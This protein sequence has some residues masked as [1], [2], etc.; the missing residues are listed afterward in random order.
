M[1]LFVLGL[2]GAT[3]DCLNPL[4][5]EGI[6]PNI[7]ELCTHGA[8]GPLQTVF[9]PVTAPA[10]LA[11]ATGLNPGK[12]GVFDYINRKTAGGNEMVPVSSAYYQDKAV[13]DLLGRSNFKVGIFNYPTLS[14]PPKVNGFVVS[15]MGGYR[16]APLSFPEELEK[17]L[18]KLTGGYE[19][20]L[21]LRNNKYRKDVN[22]FFEDVNRV[23]TKQASALKYL[24]T[25]KEWDFFFAVFHFT[26]WMQHLLW[27]HIDD[28]HLLY[29][30]ILSPRI[31]ARFKNTWT[32]I[33]EIIGE[34]LGLIG[35]TSFMIVS[36]H[37]A[38]P[39]DSAF[40]PNTWLEQKGL[41][42]K[43]HLGW[44]GLLAE[45]L[46]PLSADIDNKYLSAGLHIL[47]TRI[48]KSRGTM[49][50][51]DL[52]NSLAYSPEHAGMFGCISLTQ[53]GKGI[54]GIKED[55][56]HELK[57]LPKNLD[58]IN[59][60]EIYLP[61]Q[62]YS[63]PYVNLAP[64]VLFVIN[65]YRSTVEIDFTKSS[66]VPSP[67]IEMRTGSH[68]PQGVFMAKG[69]NFKNVRLKNVSVLDI[70][71]TILALYD[72]EIPAQIDGK[73]I[74]ECIRPEVLK[75]MRIRRSQ[76]IFDDKRQIEENGDL[77]EMKRTLESMGYM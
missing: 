55:L 9:P 47:K 13:W 67:S 68:R 33:D 36:D 61:E 65:G 37:G 45:K 75:S 62:I 69:D 25:Q 14:P 34:L 26:D 15:G 21:N 42:K 76:E 23:I 19:F 54:D 11:L 1:K 77:E 74:T 60:V 40:Y 20:R 5:E 49:D 30:R 35:D 72:V 41:L 63:G 64:D 24:V 48:L 71:P 70:A 4:M 28:N 2:D 7:K 10:W 31:K 18:N 73:V 27:K 43:N 50:L 29:D 51:I 44:R 66:F 38:G 3:F 57:N 17:E 52:E 32:R 46:K 6:I 59:E 16:K 8:W 22:L 56:I 58:R 39:I 53:K 12:T